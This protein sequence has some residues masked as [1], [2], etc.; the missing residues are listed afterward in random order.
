MRP[1]YLR[2]AEDDEEKAKETDAGIESKSA[3]WSDGLFTS[4]SDSTPNQSI[5]KNKPHVH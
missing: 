4:S 2:V 5:N 3:G 1:A